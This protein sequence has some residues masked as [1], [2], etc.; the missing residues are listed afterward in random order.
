M[1]LFNLNNKKPLFYTIIIYLFINIFLHFLKPNFCYNNNK[2]LKWGIGENKT[3]FPSLLFSLI[4]SIFIYLIFNL[5]L[6]K[7]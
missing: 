4:F 2:K 7:F 3:L 5:I 1:F 6:F